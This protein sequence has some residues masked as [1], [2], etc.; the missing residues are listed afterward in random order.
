MIYF[1]HSHTYILQD[2]DWEFY[3]AFIL[4]TLG[5]GI[6]FFY[7]SRDIGKISDVVYK[8]RHEEAWSDIRV[9]NHIVLAP[10]RVLAK[11]QVKE[12]FKVLCVVL[13]ELCN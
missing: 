3:S 13:S 1:I 12:K 2:V 11:D 10:D 4:N 6:P 8:V 9:V 5:K 7:F